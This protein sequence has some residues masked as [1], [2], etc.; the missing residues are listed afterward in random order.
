MFDIE[1]AGWYHFVM[2]ELRPTRIILISFYCFLLGLYFF[3]LTANTIFGNNGISSSTD[4]FAWQPV[5]AFII[6]AFSLIA[7]GIGLLY[8]NQ[9]CWKMLF[10]FLMIGISTVVSL[11]LVGLIFVIVNTSLFC[12]FYQSLHITSGDWISFFFFFVLGIFVLYHHT[13]SEIMNLFGDMG[14]LISPF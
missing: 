4:I 9:L 11:I 8:Y 10:F 13:R 3:S 14:D 1:T 12:A 7:V 6:F 2:I 5:I